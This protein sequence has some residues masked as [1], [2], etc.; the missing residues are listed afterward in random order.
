MS[1]AAA[2]VLLLGTHPRAA[3]AQSN[4]PRES[5]VSMGDSGA[6]AIFHSVMVK[7]NTLRFYLPN[8]LADGPVDDQHRIPDMQGY[9][10]YQF[11]SNLS[12]FRVDTVSKH[13]RNQFPE[14]CK[15]WVHAPTVM[16]EG[17]QWEHLNTYHFFIDNFLRIYATLHDLKLFDLEKFLARQNYELP[18]NREANLFLI[19]RSQSAW[20]SKFTEL[21]RF[22]TPN[23]WTMADAE[24]V[25]FR[26][27]VIGAETATLTYHPIDDPAVQEHVQQVYSEMRRYAV[28]A[29]VRMDAAQSRPPP[30]TEKYLPRHPDR[31]QV[32]IVSRDKKWWTSRLIINEQELIDEINRRYSG[33]VEVSTL[34][35][36][37]MTLANAM[38]A[39]NHT[40]FLIGMHGAG[41]TNMLWMQPGGVVIQGM[42]YGWERSPG[43]V[44]GYE[45]LAR[46]VNATYFTWRNVNPENAWLREGHF[47][48]HPGF[49]FHQHPTK[50]E[51]DSGLQY[52]EAG[53]LQ[54]WFLYQDTVVDLATFMPLVDQGMRL[55]QKPSA[56]SS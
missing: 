18:N 29:Q 30:D 10:K 43:K 42:P 45:Q 22:I 54:E 23:L 55:L 11:W 9:L 49:T 34:E 50:Q 38:V 56:Q 3:Q 41:L 53:L 4:L 31:I 32:R 51:V 28:P 16:Y 5:A 27:L 15:R 21:F 33:R 26:R 6:Y 36:H 17:I 46:N 25:C 35:F 8:H 20:K 40:D 39:M 37:D 24:G 13:N 44:L 7:G 19:Q 1:L 47:T 14:E 2:T 48:H 52:N 12:D